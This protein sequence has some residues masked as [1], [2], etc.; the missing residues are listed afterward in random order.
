VLWI[1]P[2]PTRLPAARDLR[3]LTTAALPPLP[4]PAGLDVLGVSSLPFE[5]LT[6]GRWLNATFLWPRVLSRL[7][8][9]SAGGDL[10]IGV[11]RPSDLALR[12]L[13]E[14]TS[15]WSF[16][17][18]MDDF[19]EF[20]RGRAK[21][22]QE[23]LQAE[24]AG[25]VRVVFTSSSGLTAKFRARGFQPVQ[26]AN[27]FDMR[28][29]PP[30]IRRPSRRVLGYMGCIGQW[31][32]WALVTEAARAMPDVEIHL[33]G[34]CM[35]P[36]PGPLPSNVRLSPACHQSE[37]I[38]AMSGFGAGLIP[39]ALTP[40]TAG[41]DPIKYYAYRS[42]GLPVLSTAFGEMALRRGT[43][44][45]WIIDRAADV[46]RLVDEAL[47]EPPA[48][49]AVAEFRREHDWVRR[50]DDAGVFDGLRDAARL[51]AAS[52]CAP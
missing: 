28:A 44:G 38:A 11:G 34:P 1:D 18:A 31:F 40:L 2:Y 22:V 30:V 46:S 35:A 13:V 17:D 33:I 39:F 20:Y 42:L 26:V 21:H 8:D 50:F 47:S 6:A 15:S 32:D 37:A 51:A 5:P 9:F 12:S 45:T 16:Y 10:A 23:R 43:P 19:P 3:R 27:A 29:L 49:A 25:R 41:V 24:I 52:P 48:E 14:L 4:R 36:A 7:I